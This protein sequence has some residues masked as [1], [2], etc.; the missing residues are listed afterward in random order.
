M[1]KAIFLDYT[2]TILQEDS[3]QMK[4]VQHRV[5]AAS[6]CR[7][8]DDL[9][10][11]FHTHLKAWE[12]QSVGETYRD[13]DEVVTC[14]FQSL[15][16][17]IT[18]TEDIPS[19]MKLMRSFWADGT[20][21][22]DVAPFFALC[23]LPIYIISNN[24]EDYVR[25]AMA[26]HGLT[27]GGYICAD[28]VRAYK[29]ARSL[30]ERALEVS[31]CA[32]HEVLHVGDSYDSDVM[33][34]RSAGI[35]PIHL[36]R[37]G[38]PA[39]EGVTTIS[40]LTHLIPLLK[41]E[42]KGT[43]MKYYEILFS[44]TGGTKKT[45]DILMHTLTESPVSVDLM[46]RETDFSAIPFAAEDVCLVAVPSFG[47][48][49]PVPAAQRLSRM[50]GN[51]ARVIL[52]TVYGNRHYDDTLV[53]LEDLLTQAGFR[54]VAGVAA[55]AEHSMDRTIARGRPDAQDKKEL[56]SFGQTIRRRL[57][58]GEAFSL[59]LPGNRPYKDMPPLLS[60]P[61]ATEDCGQCG[62]CAE[63]CPVGAIDAENAANTD[64]T[65]CA[66]C[67]ACTT[68]CPNGRQVPP[69]IMEKLK[70]FLAQVCQGRKPNEFF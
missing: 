62:R 50:K 7:D 9:L 34:A 17:E 19:L 28:H 69:A 57:M 15:G 39:R 12:E 30:F 42:R 31:G 26:K 11:R 14:T 63:V 20:F 8:E 66:S 38:G 37:K 16:E 33:G 36:Q 51:G 35:R 53:E 1:I 41:E 45:A 40:S 64:Q 48:R 24:G 21:F 55:V 32:P 56:E 43:Q 68:V 5:C 3:W 65:I 59:E 13:A 22:P 2:G 54:P 70:G 27:P 4:E 67:M 25:K 61:L 47:G 18:M 49:V 52:M 58:S 44:P 29:P 10:A 60:K 6:T 23:P 46:D